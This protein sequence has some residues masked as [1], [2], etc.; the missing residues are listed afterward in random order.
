MALRFLDS[1]D[2]YS[3]NDVLLKWTAKEIG[4]GTPYLVPALHGNGLAAAFSKG[5]VFGSNTIIMEAY[6]KRGNGSLFCLQDTGAGNPVFTQVTARTTEVGG[7]EVVRGIGQN[8]PSDLIWASAPDVLRSGSWYHFGWKVRVHPSAGTLDVRVNGGTLCNLTGINTTFSF[9][10]GTVGGIILGLSATG[11][12]FDDLVVMDDVD[13]GLN[14]P[15]L[16]GGGGFDKFLGPVEIVV[17]RPNGTGLLAEWVPTPSVPNWQNVDD[18][19]PDGDTT[20]NDADPTAV[21]KSDLFAMENMGADQ[22]PVAV[23]S[24]VCARKT[25]EGTAAVAKLVNDGGTTTVGPTVYQPSTYSYMHQAEPTLP[26]GS[27][28]TVAKWNA[29]QY[30]YRRMV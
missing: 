7:I 14:D 4:G 1:F 19:E 23:Q 17:K 26:D 13:D 15:R 29:I 22:D 9:W 25:E 27:L 20:Y 8:G 5:L 16:P 10:S 28:W 6:V 24:L 18:I 2:H 21:G 12:V 30:G 3:S 11:I